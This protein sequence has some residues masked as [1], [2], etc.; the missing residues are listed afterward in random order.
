MGDLSK[1]KKVDLLNASVWKNYKTNYKGDAVS[2]D[3][4]FDKR[5]T[6]EQ[7]SSLQKISSYIDNMEGWANA[8]GTRSPYYTI[9]EIQ[10]TWLGQKASR[11]LPNGLGNMI[12]AITSAVDWLTD[13]GQQGVVIDGFGDISADISVEFTKNPVVFVGSQVTD[14][15]MRTPNTVQMTI[16]V[17]NYN[18][19]NAIGTWLDSK[20]NDFDNTGLAAAAVDLLLTNGNTRAQQAL[21]KLREIQE[22]GQPF[23]VYTPHGIY[24]NMLIQSLK[25]KTTAE[26]LDMLECDITFMEMIMY[27]PYKSSN[28]TSIVARTN[29]GDSSIVSYG[30]EQLRSLW[31]GDRVQQWTGEP[32]WVKTVEGWFSSS[33]TAKAATKTAKTK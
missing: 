8:L 27:E 30:M 15:R 13:S 6:S 7:K 17:S 2:Q 16:Y 20:L 5:Y 24:Q 26:N 18:N 12:R 29:V 14:G 1:F 9:G 23:T 32:G 11:Y 33:D 19:D 31:T 25:P 4:S 22:K 3:K 28:T 21:Y 10:S